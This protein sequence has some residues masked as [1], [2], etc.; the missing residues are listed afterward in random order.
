MTPCPRMSWWFLGCRFEARHDKQAISIRP[1]E[2]M[3]MDLSGEAA[4]PPRY[5]GDI[6][7]RCGAW[8]K[9]LVPKASAP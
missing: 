8:A 4:V 5:I 3:F 9:D 7:I 2:G 6:C 1:R